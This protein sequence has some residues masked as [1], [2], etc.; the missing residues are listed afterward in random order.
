[1]EKCNFCQHR[2][3]AAK[4]E[5]SN[6]GRDGQDGEVL[7][8]CQQTCATK[9]ITFG[10]LMDENSEVSKN[11]KI[12]DKEHRDRQYE[13]LPELNFQPAVTYMKK[14]NTRVAGGGKHGHNTSHG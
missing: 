3:V 12:N 9:A 4:H 1:M 13:V 5:A 10:N 7:T 2:L 11:A 14:V 8:A 6:L